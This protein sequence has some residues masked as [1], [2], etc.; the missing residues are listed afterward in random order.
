MPPQNWITCRED[1]ERFVAEKLTGR[2]PGIT[3][4]SAERNM[5]C[6]VTTISCPGAFS[7]DAAGG[8]AMLSV[9]Q[10]LSGLHVTAPLTADVSV[11][12]I[13]LAGIPGAAAAILPATSCTAIP[14]LYPLL[15][16]PC[17]CNE[18]Y[19]APTLTAFASV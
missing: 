3:I 19:R 9:K 7:L 13:V 10:A 6:P 18:A 2:D 14:Q 15:E 16:Q 5:N 1:A 4:A 12:A 8:H 11:T 17:P